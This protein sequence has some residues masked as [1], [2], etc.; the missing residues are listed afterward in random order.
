MGDDG[1]ISIGV[2]S[3]RYFLHS[4]RDELRHAMAPSTTCTEP[5]ARFR[6]SSGGPGMREGAPSPLVFG[7]RTRAHGGIK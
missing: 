1:S 2:A 6:C 4:M 5:S 7:V 3:S